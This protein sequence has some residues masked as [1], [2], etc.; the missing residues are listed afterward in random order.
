MDFGDFGDALLIFLIIP[1]AV[2]SSFKNDGDGPAIV[3]LGQDIT[4]KL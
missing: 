4:W 3:R 1:A 2:F